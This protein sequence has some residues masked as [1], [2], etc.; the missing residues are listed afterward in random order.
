MTNGPRANGRLGK[1]VPWA[2]ILLFAGMLGFVCAPSE[3]LAAKVVLNDG[4]IIEGNIAPVAGLVDDPKALDDE[5]VP[6]A[7]RIVLIDNGLCRYFVSKRNIREVLEGG[8]EPIETIKLW[9]RE[10]R[11][12]LAVSNVGSIISIGAFDDFGRRTF[13]MKTERG[14]LDVIQ[15]I[16]EITP[17]WVKVAGIS[18]VWDLRLATSA[19]DPELLQKMVAKVLD[20]ENVEHRLQWVRFL[21]AAE[22][23]TGAQRE[24]DQLLIDFPDLK[25]TLEQTALRVRQSAARLLLREIQ[26]RREAGQHRTVMDYLDQFPSEGVAGETLQEVRELLTDYGARRKRGDSLLEHFASDVD[27]LDPQERARVIP[28]REEIAAEL[29]FNTLDRLSAYERLK[30]DPD[31]TAQQKVALAVTGWLVGSGSAIENLVVALDLFTLR[32]LV[33]KYLREDVKLPREQVLKQIRGREGSS[34][35]MIARLIDH[36]KPPLDLPEPDEQQPGFFRLSIP[37]IGDEPEFSYLVQLPPEYDPYR[38]YPAVVTLHATATTSEM[39]VDWWAGV[40][41]PNEAAGGARRGQ[42]TRHG[43]IVVAPDWGRPKKPA[44]GYTATEHAAV[45]NC[46]RD[47]C[48]RLSIDTD[49]VFL[50]GH[51]VGGDA[52][53]D[54]GLAHPDLWAGVVPI[55]AR[56]DRYCAHYRQNARDLPFY[57]VGGEMDGEKPIENALDLEYYLNRGYDV[58]VVEYLGR[59]HEHFSDEVQTLFDW[60]RIKRRDFFPRDFA[61]RTLRP[62]DNFFWWVEVDGMPERATV[63]PE[64]WPP[65]RRTV[66]MQVKGAITADNNLRVRAGAA[67]VT[68]WLSPEMVDFNKRVDIAVNGTRVRQ[69]GGQIEPKIE[70]LLE[71]ARTRGDRQHPFWSRVDV[72]RSRGR[73]ATGR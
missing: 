66:S 2:N 39:Q 35:P 8:S 37:G 59:G 45:L 33:R 5:G 24:L 71:D 42:A 67:E 14:P 50:S 51:G 53:W 64:D 32:N 41:S 30:D 68:V 16:T 23:Y 47:A 12:G 28:I 15:G 48:R 58:T 34:V 25:P 29:N 4:R 3:C 13:T 70:V 49:R 7:Q 63:L 10:K 40:R 57:L 60:M 9:Q 38:R 56:A 54:M 31:L 62:W 46:L 22:R 11:G 27:A 21:L 55:A 20:P 17:R 73:V 18:H 65:S 36:M 1:P 61:C 19:I 69:S 6:L 72:N 44:Y 52:A 26:H 43:F